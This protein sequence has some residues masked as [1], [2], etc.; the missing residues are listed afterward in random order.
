MQW[1]NYHHLY[2]FWTVA[3]E[4]SIA[5]AS[6]KLRLSQPTIS[7]QLKR[8]EES[9]N[10]KLFE[11]T[12]RRLVLTDVG[13][14]VYR[15][16]E[17]IFSLGRE[18]T[19]TI[20]SQT[21]AKGTRLRVGVSDAVPK[22]VTQKLL[23]PILGEDSHVTLVCTEDKPERL[24][25][26]LGA[27]HLDLVICDAPMPPGSRVRAYNHFLG[28]SAVMLMA[29]PT[30]ARKLKKGFPQSL[31]GAPFILPGQQSAVRRELEQW[32]S[33]VEVQ[34]RVVAEVDDSALAK[35]LAD[36][37]HGVMA[38]PAILAEELR[39]MFRLEVVAALPTVHERFY[40][41]TV[42]RKIS[43]PAVAAIYRD[44]RKRLFQ[45]SG[46]A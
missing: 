6:K 39:R 12:G 15:Y 20:R 4:G 24:M 42:E 34:P 21:P 27:H 31:D 5:E 8:L 43:H 19:E 29:V 11:R 16:A 30:L 38:L 22:L 28:E 33:S 23:E 40:A 2:Y 46:G 14:V 18:M 37:G 45:A 13:R 17:D 26:D 35:L 10:E 44:A 1:L 32:F 7:V 3:R 9:L 25:T 36:N 41:I